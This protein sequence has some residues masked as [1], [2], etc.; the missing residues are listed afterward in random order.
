MHS[1]FAG[2]A[3]L[4]GRTVTDAAEMVKLLENT[5]RAVNIG[6]VNEVALMAKRLG[7]DVWEAGKIPSRYSNAGDNEDYYDNAV[8]RFFHSSMFSCEL[9]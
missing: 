1:M 6:L 5:F 7:I 2:V 9:N 8:S 4:I 3:E